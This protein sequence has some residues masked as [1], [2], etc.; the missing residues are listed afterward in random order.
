MYAKTRTLAIGEISF[1]TRTVI[2]AQNTHLALNIGVATTVLGNS[3]QMRC[4]ALVEVEL[5]VPIQTRMEK[6]MEIMVQPEMEALVTV[7]ANH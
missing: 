5:A 3:D 6:I 7:M 2:L 4:V 1:L